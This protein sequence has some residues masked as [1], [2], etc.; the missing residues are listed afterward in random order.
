MSGGQC[1]EG[2]L[3]IE[4]DPDYRNRLDRRHCFVPV[5]IQ[6]CD[7]CWGAENSNLGPRQGGP[8]VLRPLLSPP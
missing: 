3:P 2:G 6:G 7:D 1:R 4:A 8:T 5:G